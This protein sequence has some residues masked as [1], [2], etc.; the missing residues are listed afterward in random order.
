[1]VLDCALEMGFLGVWGGMLVSVMLVSGFAIF[2][3]V[4]GSTFPRTIC[5]AC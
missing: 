3:G 5:A 2:L 4:G 1:M